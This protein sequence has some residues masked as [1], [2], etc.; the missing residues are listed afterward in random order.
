[1]KTQNIFNSELELRTA[2][3]AGL[4]KPL[5]GRTL[6]GFILVVANQCRDCL[7]GE[8]I[9]DKLNEAFEQIREDYAEQLNKPPTSE[10]SEDVKV[11]RQIV[12]CGLNSLGTTRFRD[13]GKEM[14]RLQVNKVRSF[15][16]RRLAAK[17]IDSVKPAGSF[18]ELNPKFHFDMPQVQ[19]EKFWEGE[20]EG[21]TASLF[22]NKYPFA[23]VHGV[24]VLERQNHHLQYL[25]ED[26]HKWASAVTERIGQRIPHFGM[27]YNSIGAFASVAHLHWQTFVE[28][29][30]LPITSPNWS[31][32]SPQANNEYPL[33]CDV[34][35]KVEDSW[36]WIGEMHKSD[37]TSYNLIY[38]P[39]KTFCFRRRFQGH[40]DQAIWT[41]GFA[42]YEC[43]GGMITLNDD[44][45]QSLTSRM[46][47][48]E[49]AKLGAQ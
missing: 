45:F 20:L 42:W 28:P 31:H 18:E 27:G 24:L 38:T 6:G 35:T 21:R 10:D 13:E 46:V 14:W 15:R 3:T 1:M 19:V 39:E 11:L 49:F 8:A 32:N 5:G 33:H 44:D 30:G 23:N 12:S 9:G 26:E 25:S 43:G 41:S 16:P 36:N 47:L 34:F 40:Y 2:F 4:A 37:T 22:Y 29:D 48:D 7:I 17:R